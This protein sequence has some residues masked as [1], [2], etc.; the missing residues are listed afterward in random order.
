LNSLGICNPKAGE[1]VRE[2][3]PIRLLTL[4]AACAAL[5]AATAVATSQAA[6]GPGPPTITL[7]FFDLST[8]FAATIPPNQRPKIGDR[9]WFHDEI[10]R[11]NGAK[12]GAHAGHVE[13]TAVVLAGP[14]NVISA[15]AFLPGATI[16]IQGVSSFTSRTSTYA[17]IGGTGAF[18]T[19]RGEVIVRSLGGQNSNRSAIIVRL[20]M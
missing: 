20:W 13:G 16:D 14:L 2:M 12:R 4:V 19:A 15:T 11:W 8:R 7:R 10:F 18:A 9:F 3:K 1:E 6:N 5:A 17:V